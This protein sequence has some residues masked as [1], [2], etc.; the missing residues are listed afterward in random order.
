MKIST[1]ACW[2][3]AILSGRNVHDIDRVHRVGKPNSSGKA[4]QII[5]KFATYRARQK[6][7]KNRSRLREGVNRG[8]YINEDLTRTRSNL[9]FQARQ[10]VKT[11]KID[12]AW[13]SDGVILLRGIKDG[14]S[15]FHRILTE[16]DLTRVAS[17]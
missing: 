11:G 16:D 3:C 8:V 13:S 9:L 7:Y 4:R 12:S 14:K 5:V 1:S 15:V 17:D 2:I 10:M 6:V